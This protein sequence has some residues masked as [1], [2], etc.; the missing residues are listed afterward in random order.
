MWRDALG[1][2][3]KKW[4][5][6]YVDNYRHDLST[7]FTPYNLTVYLLSLY[8]KFIVIVSL[9]MFSLYAQFSLINYQSLCVSA[10]CN[11]YCNSLLSVNIYWSF[12]TI[13]VYSEVSF[14]DAGTVNYF[15][16]LCDWLILVFFLHFFAIVL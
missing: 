13:F 8:A 15:L 11:I 7:W 4:K 3:Y 14:K 10:V 1:T 2:L 9:F 16:Y 5:I 12:T 6:H